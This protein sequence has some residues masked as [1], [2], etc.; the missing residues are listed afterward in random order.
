[1]CSRS[2]L[3]EDL[4]RFGKEMPRRSLTGGRGNIE[5]I[6]QMS[7]KQKAMRQLMAIEIKTPQDALVWRKQVQSWIGL[8]N[9]DTAGVWIMQLAQHYLESGKSERAAQTIEYLAN[10]WPDH[11]LSPTAMTWLIRYYASSEFSRLAF[12][13]AKELQSQID[14]ANQASVGAHPKIS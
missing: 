1:M 6:R 4:D 10:R 12:D 11:A 8:L 9:E 3:F 7:Q 13:E 2:N 14:K 5:M